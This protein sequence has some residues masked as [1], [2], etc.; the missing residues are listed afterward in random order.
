MKASKLVLPAVLIT[1]V[2]STT[3]LSGCAG[4]K[5]QHKNSVVNKIENK[6]ILNDIWVLEAIQGEIITLTPG[7]E[8]P[9]LEIQL[10]SMRIMGTDGCNGYFGSI[11]YI[12]EEKITF[13]PIGST[14]KYCAEMTIPDKFGQQMTAVKAYQIEG[15]K[16]R[17]IDE[18]GNEVLLFQKV[19]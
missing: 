17:L 8:R 9:R 7:T 12:D 16:L 18:S 1:A 10:S 11:N 19:D 2:F 4:N 13:G 6:I 14:R 3:F 15:L 5:I